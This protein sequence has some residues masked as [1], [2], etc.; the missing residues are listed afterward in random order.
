MDIENFTRIV[1]DGCSDLFLV[2]FV[3]A[4]F[5]FSKSQRN[6]DFISIS[7]LNTDWNTIHIIHFLTLSKC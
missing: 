5:I 4:Y 3:S 2:S 7:G 6:N 1:G